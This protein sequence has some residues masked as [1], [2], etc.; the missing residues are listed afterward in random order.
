VP[1]QFVQLLVRV[2]PMLDEAW[3][4]IEQRYLAIQA[5]KRIPESLSSQN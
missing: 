2:K 4:L 5:N 1:E 3:P